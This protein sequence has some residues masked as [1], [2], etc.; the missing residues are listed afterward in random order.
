[1]TNSRV[2][3][4]RE[5]EAWLAEYFAANGW[6]GAE[7]RPAGLP[8]SDIMG[9]PAFDIEVKSRRDLKL[10]QWLKQSA[11][12]PGLSMVIHRPDGFGKEK[13]GLWPVTFRL[14][15]ATSLLYHW[16][17]CSGTSC[18]CGD[19]SHEVSS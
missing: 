6:P 12:R 9:M 8:G 19:D 14:Q 16:D 4:G 2:A 1:M 7:R 5:S 18:S 10:T 13:L 17:R 15:D 11:P 3:R